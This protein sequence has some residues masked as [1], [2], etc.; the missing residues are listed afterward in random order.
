MVAS[1]SS[2]KSSAWASATYRTSLNLEGMGGEQLSHFLGL[3]HRL[4]ALLFVALSGVRV[5]NES[6]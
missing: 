1:S 5:L 2:N 4:K 3:S 6:F